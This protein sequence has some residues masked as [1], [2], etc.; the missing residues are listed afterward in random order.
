MH[1]FDSSVIDYLKKGFGYD[2]AQ[3]KND[4][5]NTAVAIRNVVDNSFGIY[6]Y[7]G[8]SCKYKEDPVNFKYQNLPGGKDL[9]GADLYQVLK[10][11]FERFAVNSD[12]LAF[13]GHSQENES[14]NNT[15]ASKAPKSHFYGGT[16]SH[17]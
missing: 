17:R 14:F 10:D 5:V 2:L 6:N 11:L 13:G 9:K 16:S 12:S 1:K 3:N 15:V 4:S 8:S 7:C